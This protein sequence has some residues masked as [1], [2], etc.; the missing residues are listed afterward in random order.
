MNF[1]AI[2]GQLAWALVLALAASLCGWI[3]LLKP[4][5]ERAARRLFFVWV[6]LIAGTLGVWAA[7]VYVNCEW[8]WILDLCGGW[9]ACAYYYW[10]AGGCQ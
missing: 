4:P 9:Q 2:A 3:T 1:D 7:D 10:F 5:S 8:A 6:F